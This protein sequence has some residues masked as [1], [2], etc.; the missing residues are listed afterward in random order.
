MWITNVATTLVPN[1]TMNMTFSLGG[2]SNGVPYDVFANPVLGFGTNT[3]PW[4]WMGQGYHCNRYMVTNL[5]IESVFLVLGT[6][7]DLDG[8]GLTDAFENLVSHTDPNHADTDGDGIPDSWEV[9][10]GLNPLINDNAQST[11]RSNYSY[12]LVDWLEGISG[13]RTGSVSLDAEGNVL[14]VSQ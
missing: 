2:G 10:L 6:P 12:D 13:A 4:I 9:L 5:P 1:G 8:D 7:Q 14:S 3:P 11:S